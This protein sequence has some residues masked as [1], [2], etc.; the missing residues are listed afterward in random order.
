MNEVPKVPQINIIQVNHINLI[1]DAVIKVTECNSRKMWSQIQPYI[2]LSLTFW[3]S[4][5]EE[6]AC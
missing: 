6:N 5:N 2:F 3:V 4:V 1:D